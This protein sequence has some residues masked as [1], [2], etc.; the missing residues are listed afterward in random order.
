MKKLLGGLV[1]AGVFLAGCGSSSPTCTAT[2]CTAK[3]A[4]CGSLSD[5]CGGTLQCGTCGT[6]LACGNGQSNSVANVCGFAQPAGTV[7]V[8]FEVEIGRAHV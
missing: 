1:L 3:G 8:D 4:N 7:T 6:G 5:G 2:T